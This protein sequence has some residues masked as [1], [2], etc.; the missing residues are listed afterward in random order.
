MGCCLEYGACEGRPK[1]QVPRDDQE[2]RG[3]LE[4]IL[5][6][7]ATCFVGIFVRRSVLFETM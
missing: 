5:D 1:G 7:D 3:L 2:A 4:T 6:G